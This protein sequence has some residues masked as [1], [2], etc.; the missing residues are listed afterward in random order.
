[1]NGKIRPESRKSGTNSDGVRATGNQVKKY[2]LPARRST[3]SNGKLENLN[4][5]N[6]ENN[7]KRNDDETGSLS[8]VTTEVAKRLEERDEHGQSMLHF[9]C[10][11]SNRRGYLMNLI[12]DSHLDISYR[13]EL[14]RTARDVAMQANQM[15]NVKEIDRYVLSLVMAGDTKPFEYLLESGYDHI[16]DIVDDDSEKSI[17]D[18]AKDRGNLELM[19]YLQGLRPLE[20]QREEL[21]QMIRDKN[22]RRVQEMMEAGN[23]KWLIKAKNYYGKINRFSIKTIKLEMK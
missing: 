20:E 4:F 18:L 7:D 16:L 1:M 15:G 23:G 3:N 5:D 2:P 14:Y 9:A 8:S 22:V 11:R 6:E 21:H 10:A 12:Q 17:I 19:E 13:D